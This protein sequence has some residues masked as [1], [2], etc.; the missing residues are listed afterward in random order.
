MFFVIFFLRAITRRQW[1]AVVL[2][3]AIFSFPLTVGD[4]D[5]LV[6]VIPLIIAL[7]VVTALV[8]LRRGLLTMTA[9]ILTGSLLTNAPLTTD[10]SAWYSGYTIAM[11]IAILILAGWAFH[12]SLGGQ[13]LFSG[14]LL[15]D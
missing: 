15:E 2:F 12:T 6:S 8:F 13:K 5:P 10:F 11:M 1:V 9:A 4:P 7:N 14:S 3:V